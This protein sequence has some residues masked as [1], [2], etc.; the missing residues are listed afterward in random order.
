MCGIIGYVG[1]SPAAPILIE[2]LRRLEYRGY[3]SAGVALLDAGQ[4]NVL[5]RKG[6]IDQGLGPLLDREPAPGSCG[7]GHTRWATH[8]PPSDVNSHPHRDQSQSIA[9]VHNG[10]IENYDR[11]KERLLAGGHTFDSATDTEVLAHLIGEKWSEAQ[12]G[13]GAVTN[14]ESL[15]RAVGLA[16]REVIGTYG[17]AVVCRD[18]PGVIVGARRGSPL[19]VGVG[20]GA[21]YLAS[22]AAAVVAHTRQ[23]VYL[24]DYDVVTVTADGFSVT[25]LGTETAQVQIT[26]LE[27]DAEAAERG[28][29]PHFMLKE[30]FEQPATIRNALRGRI[31]SEEATAKF[32]GLNMTTAELRAVDRIVITACGTSWHAGLVGEY[33][34]E[35]F[36]HVPVEVEYASEFR[37][38]NAPLDKHTLL[39]VITQSGETADTLAGLREARRRGHKALAICNVVGSTIAREADGGIYLHAGPE[40][41]VAST[42]AFTSQVTVLTLFALLMGRIRMLSAT[43]GSQ[44]LRALEAV[45]D[46]LQRILDQNER[47]RQIALKYAAA[48]DFFF[49]GRQ[50]QFPVALEGALKLKEISYIHAEGYPAAEMKHGPIAMIDERTPTVVLAPADALYDKTHS[51]LQEIKARHG[52]TVAITTEG[53]T[54]LA[55]EVDD[56]LYVPAT[57]DPLCP[58][59]TVLPLQ[60]L[61]YHIAVA[62]GCDVDK[63]RNL[64]KSV[65]VE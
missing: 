25:N 2:G 16:L 4:L 6:K 19:L 5:K 28:S 26:R 24:N 65:T 14:T 34:L 21:N 42:K 44:L 15:A 11:L 22:D 37:Y 40:I 10:V 17:L 50:Y 1:S 56:I 31:D 35:E 52:P 46:Q 32:G 53:N 45:P 54:R 33:L 55:A 39:V 43:R 64:A 20:E 58:L 18:L 8:G 7:I 30:I 29:Y 59:L 62:R 36:A 57:S 61:A 9:V 63:P 13:G 49:I 41:G 23:V 27:F 48:E 51:N 12:A 3:D 60:L 47:I 38:R